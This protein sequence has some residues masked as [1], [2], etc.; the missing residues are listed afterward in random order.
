MTQLG[1]DAVGYV[2]LPQ[3]TQRLNDRATDAPRRC[4]VP[5]RGVPED[6]L[7]LTHAHSTGLAIREEDHAHRHLL[8][9]PQHVGRM[10]SGGLQPGALASLQCADNGG[11]AWKK[12]ASL[13][14]DLGTIV[15][16]TC[17]SANSTGPGRAR[18]RGVD[19]GSAAEIQ[20]VRRR[21]HGTAAA[22][23]DPMKDLLVNGA[24]LGWAR[25][26]A[27]RIGV[28]FWQMQGED[29]APFRRAY[30]ATGPGLRHR[31][32]MERPLSGLSWAPIRAA[33]LRSAFTNRDRGGRE[34]TR[35][36]GRLAA[37]L[38][39][40][41]GDRSCTGR[42]TT[43]VRDPRLFT[44]TGG[45]LTLFCKLRIIAVGG[46]RLLRPCAPSRLTVRLPPTRSDSPQLE[47]GRSRPRRKRTRSEGATEHATTQQALG[48]HC[49]PARSLLR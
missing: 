1:H 11:C 30:S 28:F 21:E 45:R 16:P 10:G 3:P 5:W 38:P 33:R 39:P 41:G 27:R 46:H 15:Q 40:L 12:R 48:R 31:R 7:A 36:P 25:S 26:H 49:I 2:A 37:R 17:Q 19:R 44:P 34:P 24:G 32:V 47:G 14:I 4:H 13:R 6:D 18:Q 9:E 20:K 8:A 35:S 23:G 42:V 43:K 29:R 22:L